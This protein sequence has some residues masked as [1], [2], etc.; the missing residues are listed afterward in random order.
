MGRSRIIHRPA[1]HLRR[2]RGKMPRLANANRAS[3]TLSGHGRIGCI[4]SGWCVKLSPKSRGFS[5]LSWLM[6]GGFDCGWDHCGQTRGRIT[7]FMEDARCRVCHRLVLEVPHNDP[8]DESPRPLDVDRLTRFQHDCCKV[9]W[10]L[11]PDRRPV[12]HRRHLEQRQQ[13]TRFPAQI[14]PANLPEP[15]IARK[16]TGRQ[17][18]RIDRVSERDVDVESRHLPF[19]RR[20]LSP[21]LTRIARIVLLLPLFPSSHDFLSKG[22]ERWSEWP[23]GP[24]GGT[25]VSNAGASRRPV[26]GQLR[27]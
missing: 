10:H 13:G 17:A 7:S 14:V 20:L 18:E 2:P 4:E 19:A 15:S 26:P 21:W 9:F 11:E 5:A 16:A 12:A 24:D 3:R 6:I 27:L 25:T 23:S 8:P 1:T 22:S